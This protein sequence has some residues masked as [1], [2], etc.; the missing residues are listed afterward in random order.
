MLKNIT[1]HPDLFDWS[2]QAR[3]ESMRAKDVVVLYD[4]WREVQAKLEEIAARLNSLSK[5]FTPENREE[6]IKLNQSKEELHLEAKSKRNKLD[7]LLDRL[8]NLLDNKVPMGKSEHEN[9]VVEYCGVKP[10]IANPRHHEDI[11]LELGMWSRDEAVRMSGSRFICLTDKLAKLERVLGQFVLEKNIEVGF[12]EISVPYLVHKHALYNTGQLPK[13]TED[14]FQLDDFALI[15]TGEVP[16]VNYYSGKTLENLAQNPIKITAQT[17]CFRSEAGSLGRDTKGLIRVHQF[18]KVEMVA[19]TTPEESE[20]MHFYLLDQVKN[21]LDLLGLHYRVIEICSGDIGFTAARQFD[22]E[23]WMPGQN[24]Y[25]EVSSCSNC[26]DFQ[27]RRMKTKYRDSEGKM[28][29]VHTLNCTGIAC[30][31][32][33]AAILENHCASGDFVLPQCLAHYYNRSTGGDCNV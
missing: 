16:L 3:G 2:M 17:P 19:I 18:Q 31:R 27:S 32:I 26:K 30:G 12:T 8:P 5:S 1:Q 25:V 9:M 28:N 23:V 21:T 13:F 11:A 22:V 20:S 24:K 7:H 33:V 14:F 4:D 10:E 15:P 6:A 29:F